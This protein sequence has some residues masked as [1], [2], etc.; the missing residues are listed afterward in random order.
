MLEILNARVSWLNDNGIE[1]AQE[2][3]EFKHWCLCVADIDEPTTYLEIGSRNGG[4][5]YVAAGFLPRN[6][7]VIAIDLPGGA[8]GQDDSQANLEFVAQRLRDEGYQV[9]LIF[10][11]SKSPVVKE[12]LLTLLAEER[13]RCVFIDGDHT[14]AGV[15]SDWNTVIPLMHAKGLIALH[16]ISVRSDTPDV[17]VGMFWKNLQKNFATIDIVYR[18]GIGIANLDASLR[19]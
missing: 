19:K 8:W 10:G 12:R 3:S 18:Y 11:D 6:S 2:L 9:D 14:E 1:F 4:S 13:L 17:E 7:R 15:Q 5:L 16:D